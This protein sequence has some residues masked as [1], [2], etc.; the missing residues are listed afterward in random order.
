MSIVL[1]MCAGWWESPKIFVYT[2]SI[3]CLYI[4]Q[5]PSSIFPNIFYHLHTTQVTFLV[6]RKKKCIYQSHSINSKLKVSLLPNEKR[7]K[8]RACC[9]KWWNT[10]RI[11]SLLRKPSQT[12]YEVALDNTVTNGNILWGGGRWGHRFDFRYCPFISSY[13]STLVIFL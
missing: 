11:I 6:P 8:T 5:F 10:E 9:S 1:S 4:P 13:C 2:S 7:V 3:L 12:L